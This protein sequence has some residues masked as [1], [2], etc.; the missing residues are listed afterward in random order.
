MSAIPPRLKLLLSVFVLSGFAGLIY[1]S[2]WSHYLGL[3][4]GHAAYAQALVL[5]IFMGGMALGAALIARVGQEWRNLI[6]SYAIIEAIIGVLA[7]VFHWVFVGIVDFSYNKLIPVLEAPGL[8]GIYK[9]LL[10]TLLIL[11]QTILL[12][13]TFPLMSGGI[14]RRFSGNDGSILGGLYFTNSIGA[15][16]GVLAVAFIFLP[17]LG[18][19]GAILTAGV[20]NLVVAA[21]AWVLS[22]GNEQARHAVPISNSTEGRQLSEERRRLLK[23]VL[24]ATFFSGAAS[25]AYEIIWIR[26]LSL[27][28]GSTLHAFELMLAAFIAGIAFGG[29]WVRRRADT[30]GDPMRLVGWLQVLMGLAALVSLFFYANAFS[31]VGFLMESLS[32]TD[33]GYQ[34]YNLGTALIAI[35]IMMPAAFFAGTTLP[36]FT[37]ALL[38]NGQGEPSIGR[39]YAWN[40]LGAILGVFATI[41]FLIPVLGLKLALI[42]A[43]VVDMLVGVIL[44]RLNTY[45]QRDFIGTGVAAAI[46][47]FATILA[48]TNVPFDPM[49]LSSGVYRTGLTELRH[50]Q[51][52][53]IY[54]RDG[55][56]ASVA[57]IVDAVNGNIRIATNGK[58]DAAIRFSEK[59]LISQDE[60]TMVLL[61][62][63]PLGYQDTPSRVGIIGFGSGLST[64]AVLGDSRVKRVDTV[65]IESSMVDG[66]RF[67]GERVERAYKDPRSHI[68]IDDAKSY[69]SSQQQKYDLIISEPSNPWISGVGSLFSK[70]FYQHVPKLLNEDGLF[71]QWLQL[72]EIDEKLVGSVL[73]ALTPAFADYHAYLANNADLIIVASPARQL[74]K[75]D[76]SRL[77]S[78]KIRDDLAKAGISNVEQITFRR[79]ADKKLL[80]TLSRL[81]PNRANSDYFPL[82]SIN[83]PKTRYKGSA[84]R[85]IMGLPTIDLPLLEV[86]GIV[87]PKISLEKVTDTHLFTRYLSVA[88][89]S[90]IAESLRPD[91]TK[92]LQ[93]IRVDTTRIAAGLREL[94]RCPKPWTAAQESAAIIAALQLLQNTLA[95]LPV[96]Q[97]EGVLINPIWIECE[98]LPTEFAQMLA[99]MGALAK[100]DYTEA[101]ILL[102][103]WLDNRESRNDAY[104]ILDPTFYVALQLVQIALGKYNNIELLE[105]QY[106]RSIH[107]D[108]ELLFVR[109]LL[110]AWV[111]EDNSAL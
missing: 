61:P 24:I 80:E 74:T 108:G 63:I 5:A 49:K 50:E 38:R 102:R 41:H 31:W 2:I 29:F 96:D 22:R 75:P 109:S 55:K 98:Q 30:T 76:F 17:N 73:A 7:L 58:I 34:L 47:F 59:A 45:T 101:D 69:F 25:F 83:A 56:T 81:Y 3:F 54:Y 37:V 103:A 97:Q 28:V 18:L 79:V 104:R 53:V 106:G 65:E 62:A 8:V 107:T 51:D 6:R 85:A 89:A 42:L 86:L 23:V 15:A 94:G 72:Y 91:S 12:G 88:N 87:E 26:M 14:I 57:T 68:I 110:M 39:V 52:K 66:A 64:H 11:P 77:F 111:D 10:A 21:L 99:L 92:G 71:V 93:E 46:I 9:W 60:P 84:A 19:H 105:E 70:E 78:E 67:F 32:R 33:G 44:L 90:K 100:R 82:L 1:Q 16:L 43:A 36:L 35:L 95:H 48:M 13:M 27:A 4:L 20:L 40:T